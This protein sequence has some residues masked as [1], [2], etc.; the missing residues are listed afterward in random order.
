[1]KKIEM[2]GRIFGKLKVL[3]EL[4]KNKNGHIKYKCECECGKIKDIFGTHLRSG[5][6]VSCGCINNVN[7]EGGINGELWYN[8]TKNKISKRIIRKNLSFDLTKEY[9]YDL[10]KKQNGKCNLSGIE[11]TLPISWNDKTY[12][13]SLDRIDS[14]K[15]YEIGNVQW[16]HKHINVMKNIF[17]QNMFIFLCN[18]VSENHKNCDYDIELLNNFKWGLNTKYYES[19]LGK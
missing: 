10:Y 12:T 2:V 4:H 8:L 19:I 3:S 14:K 18:K 11:I 5:K 1:M 6:I 13:A 15:G 9:I 17:E 7:K 16:V